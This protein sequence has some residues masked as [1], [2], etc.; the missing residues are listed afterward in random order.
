MCARGVGYRESP[1]SEL[2]L[3]S[4]YMYSKAPSQRQLCLSEWIPC[5]LLSFVFYFAMIPLDAKPETW[6]NCVPF[7]VSFT[8]LAL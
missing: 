3:L 7:Y 5:V 6:F 4:Y 1:D 2:S 8:N